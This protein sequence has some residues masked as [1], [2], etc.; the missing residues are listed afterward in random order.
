M[1]FLRFESPQGRAKWAMG[2]VALV[3]LLDV[4][5]GASSLMQLGMLNQLVSGANVSDA[6]LLANDS[7]ESAI[8]VAYLVM[9]V[10]SMAFFLRWFH[11]VYSNLEPLGAHMSYTPGWAIG[12]WFVPLINLIRPY[13][14]AVETWNGS[15]PSQG[16]IMAAP[17]VQLWWS[18]WII[19]NIL[20]NFTARMSTRAT[21]AQDLILPTQLSIAGSVIGLVSG[22]L[23][24]KMIAGLTARQIERAK[25]GESGDLGS[26]F[27]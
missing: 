23:A 4:I 20:G 8:G 21:S 25:Q 24:L 3:M 27:D 6:E 2:G 13:Q 10:I 22:V 19:D 7:R 18:V 11:R 1:L 5:S 16:G 14:I 26:V 15:G 9:Y 17:L 12:S